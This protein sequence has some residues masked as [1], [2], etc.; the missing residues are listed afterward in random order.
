ML[1]TAVADAAMLILQRQ[2]PEILGLGPCLS[3]DGMSR[4][5]ELAPNVSQFQMKE[6][7]IFLQVM[8]HAAHFIPFAA[9]KHNIFVADPLNPRRTAVPVQDIVASIFSNI[10]VN[11]TIKIQRVRSVLYIS[12]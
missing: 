6:H 7:D 12:M 9:T 1:N 4:S 11:P 5:F 8:H 10:L 3:T 2:Y